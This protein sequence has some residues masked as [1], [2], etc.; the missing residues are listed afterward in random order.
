V[1]DM[2][3]LEYQAGQEEQEGQ[4]PGKEQQK[5]EKQQ[6]VG[7][8]RAPGP[9]AR[10]GLAA[11]ARLPGCL[12]ACPPGSGFALVRLLVMLLL[13]LASPCSGAQQPE[14]ALGTALT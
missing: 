5:Q 14:L 12:A 7:R 13:L 3:D 8:A 10:P 11:A 2:K 4:K 1:D 6:Q 9:G